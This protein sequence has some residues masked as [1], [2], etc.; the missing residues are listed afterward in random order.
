MR[1]VLQLVAAFPVVRPLLLAV[2]RSSG[3]MAGIAS[4]LKTGALFPGSAADGSYIYWNTRVKYAERITIGRRLRVG[5]ECVL[6]GMGGIT[7]GDDVRISKGAIVE[8]GSL[9]ISGEAPYPHIAKPITIASGVWICSNAIV[10]G[11]VTVGRGAV[12]AA[13]A[14]V[15]KDVDANTIVGGNPAR[16]IKKRK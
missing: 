3:Q 1:R 15:T 10:L 12:V 7:I 5:S 9:D 11:G 2:M 13:G 4:R 8:T 14:I 6:G 16:P